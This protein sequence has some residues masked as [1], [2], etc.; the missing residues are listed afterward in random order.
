MYNLSFLCC[1][2]DK[3]FN[4]AACFLM[5]MV[6]CVKKPKITGKIEIKNYSIWFKKG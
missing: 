2:V 5:V 3:N 6:T 1:N 4:Q